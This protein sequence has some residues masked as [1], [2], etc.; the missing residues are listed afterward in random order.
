MS[1]EL[2]PAGEKCCWEPDRVEERPGREVEAVEDEVVDR[3]DTVVDDVLSA[4]G[5]EVGEPLDGVH[6]HVAHVHG[7]VPDLVGGLHSHA[8]RSCHRGVDHAH[9]AVAAVAAV[10]TTAAAAAAAAAGAGAEAGKV[11]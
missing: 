2:L 10:V 3:P 4:D 8:A 7:S 5:D 9:Q 11:L 6:R 1:V